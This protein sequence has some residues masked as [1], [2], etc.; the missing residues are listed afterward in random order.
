LISTTAESVTF[1]DIGGA[2][3]AGVLLTSGVV[4]V[5]ADIIVVLLKC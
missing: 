3:A 1:I 4:V 5:V 2:P